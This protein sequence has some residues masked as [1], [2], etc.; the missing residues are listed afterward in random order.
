MKTT[1]AAE[2]SKTL[3]SRI[4]K[5][6]KNTK[7]KKSQKTTSLSVQKWLFDNMDLRS[8]V[9]TWTELSNQNNEAATRKAEQSLTEVRQLLQQ[10]QQKITDLSN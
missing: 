9:D 8:A 6:R 3:G 2:K 10:L 1:K 7:P 4:Q 5:T